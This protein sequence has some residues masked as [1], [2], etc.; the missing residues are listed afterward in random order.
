MIT[1][2]LYPDIAKRNN[3]TPTRIERVIRVTIEAAWEK[4]DKDSREKVFGP[5]GIDG[6][7]RPSNATYIKCI[8]KYLS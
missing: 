7:K 8:V 4:A 1:K 5:L 3:T 6:M 2:L